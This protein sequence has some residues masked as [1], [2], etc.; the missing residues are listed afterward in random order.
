MEFTRTIHHSAFNNGS[1]I[2]GTVRC[3]SRSPCK[4]AIQIRTS[5][6]FVLITNYDSFR[7]SI[8]A[9]DC[10]NPANYRK[11]KYIDIRYHAIR[12]YLGKDL[13]MVDFVPSNA[14]AADILTKALGPLKHHQCV[15]LLGLRNSYEV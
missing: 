12:H 7:Q 11:A 5:R 13:I 1:R 9:Q 2:Y 3:I 15:E 8:C 4:K 14:Q 6:S 10:R